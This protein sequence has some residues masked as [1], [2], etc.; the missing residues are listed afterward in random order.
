MR[1]VNRFIKLRYYIKHL[2]QESRSKY[3]Y[4]HTVGFHESN[5][6]IVKKRCKSY[7]CEFQQRVS[8]FI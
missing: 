1:A 3:V 5:R 2:T 7:P 4:A 8:R 6:N